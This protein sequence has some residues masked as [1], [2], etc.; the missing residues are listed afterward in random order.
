MRVYKEVHGYKEIGGGHELLN[1]FIIYY[2]FIASF[3]ELIPCLTNGYVLKRSVLF[4]F[5]NITSL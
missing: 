1:C 2:Q 3:S 4:I 5:N